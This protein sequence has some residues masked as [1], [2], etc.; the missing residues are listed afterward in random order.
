MLICD[1]LKEQDIIHLFYECKQVR[2][3]WSK[4]CN[5]LSEQLG[6]KLVT[7]NELVFLFDIEAGKLTRIIN[8]LQSKGKFS[9]KANQIC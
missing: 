8:P 6:S 9:F 5:W 7:E 4:G 1:M 3:I 2:P